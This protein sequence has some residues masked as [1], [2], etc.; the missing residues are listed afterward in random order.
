MKHKIVLVFLFF[1]SVMQGIPAPQGSHMRVPTLSAV[2]YNRLRTRLEVF[3]ELYELFSALHAPATRL[4]R[5]LYARKRI[6]FEQVLKLYELS[7]TLVRDVKRFNKKMK[8]RV[9]KAWWK[10][11]EVL[12]PAAIVGALAVAAAGGYWWKQN[13]DARKAQGDKA[14]TEGRTPSDEELATKEGRD[15]AGHVVAVETGRPGAGVVGPDVMM[16]TD[17]PINAFDS[18]SQAGAG[19]RVVLGRG[20]AVTG[21]ASA[22]AIVINK[23][24]ITQNLNTLKH[25]GGCVMVDS[26]PTYPDVQ[27]FMEFVQP[28]NWQPYAHSSDPSARG[29]KK[30]FMYDGNTILN[31]PSF[32]E[33]IPRIVAALAAANSA[34]VDE[35]KHQRGPVDIDAP[36]VQALIDRF[37]LITHFCMF[38]EQ[39]SAGRAIISSQ[40]LTQD[41]LVNMAYAGT[42]EQSC[43]KTGGEIRTD[44]TGQ[45]P[46]KKFII[47]SFAVRAGLQESIINTIQDGVTRL[48]GAK[49]YTGFKACLLSAALAA[50]RAVLGRLLTGDADL[51]SQNQ[52]AA[53]SKEKDKLV[54]ADRKH[55]EIRR[56]FDQLQQL[57]R[58]G[59][60]SV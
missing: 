28:N 9:L 60:A 55:A 19:A 48:A 6:E 41:I 53:D 38:L 52:L 46:L 42:L 3:P 4:Q 15:A 26:G 49:Q 47:N 51:R 59:G 13:K 17:G 37:L 7:G 40:I 58:S 56:A 32:T 24:T 39:T 14:S 57:Q 22:Q 25:N 50:V 23:V 45:L 33:A 8:P 44:D 1:L 54:E 16:H 5:R 2:E 10:R 35:N 34:L 11:K 31:D 43:V 36:W 27:F 12:T 21:V 29:Y 20:E 18:P 30:S